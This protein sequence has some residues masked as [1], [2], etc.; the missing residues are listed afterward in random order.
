MHGAVLLEMVESHINGTYLSHVIDEVEGKIKGPKTVVEGAL[1]NK[2]KSIT[3]GSPETLIDREA[4][5]V[6]ITPIAELHLQNKLCWFSEQ[7]SMRNSADAGFRSNQMCLLILSCQLFMDIPAN[8]KSLLWYKQEEINH[9]HWLT[10][11][12]RY[13]RMLLFH[14]S[15]LTTEKTKLSRLVSYIFSV[16]LPSFLMTH[17]KPHA[18]EGPFV[19][20]FQRDLLLAFGA[21]NSD[22]C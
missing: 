21:V 20:L 3:S 10:A 4:L 5:D 18:C 14:S 13:L 17:P 12:K 16:Y 1:L 15:D 19:T 11:A 7:K 22:M 6:R 9:S 8:L 2:I